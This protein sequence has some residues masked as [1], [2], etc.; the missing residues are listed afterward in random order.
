MKNF[1]I[2]KNKIS[3]NSKTYFIADIAAN[4]DGS[5]SKAKELIH[6][7]AEAGA[8]AAKFQNF[9]ADT[10]V[11]NYGFKKLGSKFSHQSK[12]KKSVYDVYKSAEVPLSWTPILKKTCQKY[13]VDYFT[14][15]YDAN[16]LDY[17]N[18]YMSAWKIGSGDIDWHE[19]ILKIA[20]FKKPVIIATGASYLKEI[21]EIYNKVIKINK[22]IVIMQCNTNYTADKNNFNYINLNVLK[23]FKKKFP[24]AILG[25]SDHTLGHETVLGAITLGAKVIEKHFTDN[26]NRTGP[27]HKFSMNPKTWRQMIDASRNIELSLGSTIKKVEKNE[28]QTAII[29]RRSLRYKK[30]FQ[31]GERVFKKDTIPLRPA[32]KDSIG[33]NNFHKVSGKK[34]KKNVKFHEHIKL[35]DFE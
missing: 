13:N 35:S 17:L 11:S 27:D 33:L 3:E 1:K 29:Q 20:R 31:K 26:N 34:L 19:Q 16:I 15:P 30:E 22:K 32:P 5:L 9:F 25:L 8:N 24:Q 2:S 4:H 6:M 7:C 23:I 18:K 28:I 21:V 10:I 14:A 12:W